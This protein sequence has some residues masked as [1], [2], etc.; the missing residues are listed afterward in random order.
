M[1]E[2]LFKVKFHGVR[3]SIP[4][5]LVDV[6]V[7]EKLVRAFQAAKPGGLNRSTQHYNLK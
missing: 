3:G 1:A 4:S 2:N 5:P 6:D 7:E